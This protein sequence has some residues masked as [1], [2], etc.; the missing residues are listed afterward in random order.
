MASRCE[1]RRV[2]STSPVLDDARSDRGRRFR[3]RSR[4]DLV[5]WLTL[6][7]NSG[8]PQPAPLWFLWADEAEQVVIYSQPSARRLR[9]I[10]RSGRASLHLDDD[11][12][13]HGYLVMTGAVHRLRPDYPAADQNEDF[14]SKYRPS[15][16]SIFGGP[17]TYAGAFSI[18]LVFNPRRARGH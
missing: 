7:D 4:T 3:E 6:V 12:H 5:A 15:M 9:W 16:D 17:A 8:T 10:E 11:G 14:L 1:S 18:P 13:G 2:A